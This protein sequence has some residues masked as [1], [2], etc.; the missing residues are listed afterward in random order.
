[1]PDTMPEL[2]TPDFL[3]R[4]GRVSVRWSFVEALEGEFLSHLLAADPGGM[5]VITQNVAGSTITGWLR[6]LCKMRYTHATSLDRLNDLF[7][8]IDEA[9]GERNSYIHGLW[10]NGPDSG[11]CVVQ[12]VRWDRAEVVKQE[13]VTLADL[14]DLIGRINEIFLEL[15]QLGRNLGFHKGRPQPLP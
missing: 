11:A 7:N 9:R 2:L 3:V 5:Y 6:V 8:R 4:I 15:A 12:T 10:Q 13:V 14:D 1:M